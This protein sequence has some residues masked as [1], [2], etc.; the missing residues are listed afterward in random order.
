MSKEVLEQI[1]H[2]ETINKYAWTLYF[3]KVDKR[4]KQPYKAYKVKFKNEEYLLEYTKSLLASVSKYQIAPVS[5]IQ[6]YDGENTKLSC[7][8]LELSNQMISEQWGLFTDA[9]TVASDNSIKGK[10]NGYVLVGQP[11]EDGYNYIAFIK[12]ANPFTQLSNKKTVVFSA[13]AESELDLISDEVCRLYLTSDCIIY[14]GFLYAFSHSFE[15]LFSL[16]KTMVKLKQTAIDRISAINI[17]ADESYF[18]VL[19]Q[20]YKSPRTFITLSEERINRVRDKHHRKKIAEMLHIS[21][22]ENNRFIISS[23]EETSLLIR[24]LCFKIFQDN[25]TKDVLEASTV[26][27]LSVVR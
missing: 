14:N 20:R 16:E 8:K 12:T 23:E 11:I 18:K 9:I 22:D 24:Y 15:T 3:F 17:F 27:K 2:V 21:L 7:D 1:C 26:T 25:E 13:T 19:A 4:E 5:Q 10:L 6:D